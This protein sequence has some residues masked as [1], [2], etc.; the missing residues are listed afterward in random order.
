MKSST[1]KR[2]GIAAA[3]LLAL[4]ALLIWPTHVDAQ[5][6]PVRQATISWTAPTQCADG[7]PIAACPITGY[8]I[9]KQS[10]STWSSIGTTAANVTQFV[11]SDLALGTHTYRVITNSATGPSAPS[12]SASKVIAVPGPATNITVTISCTGTGCTA[13]VTTGS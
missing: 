4:Y 5:A 13:T 11:Q 2:I 3:C 12:S 6:T 1:L 8:T 7:S 10:G 9:E